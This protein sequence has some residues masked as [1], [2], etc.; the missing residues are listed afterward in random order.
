MKIFSSEVKKKRFARILAFRERISVL[1]WVAGVVVRKVA[2]VRA[3]V[4]QI[5]WQL[6]PL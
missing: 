1:D 2:S 3:I 5:R 4:V 6:A